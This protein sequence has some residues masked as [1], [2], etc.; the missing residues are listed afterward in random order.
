[1]QKA[2]KLA[3]SIKEVCRETSLSRTTIHKLIKD[4]RLTSIQVGGRTLITGASLQALLDGGADS[5]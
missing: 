5:D 4:G 1:M 3:Y 2:P